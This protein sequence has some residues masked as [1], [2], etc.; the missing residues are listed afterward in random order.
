MHLASV[1]RFT[2][3]RV[4][5]RRASVRRQV[6]GS[7]SFG[8]SL[9]LPAVR[10]GAVTAAAKLK[11]ARSAAF[12][13]SL[14]TKPDLISARSRH[15]VVDTQ[16]DGI[17][18]RQQPRSKRNQLEGKELSDVP[19]VRALSKHVPE[20]VPVRMMRW[21]PGVLVDQKKCQ[22]TVADECS[23]FTQPHI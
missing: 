16:A 20:M 19:A 7:L 23:V 22:D 21:L 2:R 8:G 4:A 1:I 12:P 5:K 10:H 15:S 17:A 3:G 6:I 18:D 11:A 14:P 13:A 9:Q